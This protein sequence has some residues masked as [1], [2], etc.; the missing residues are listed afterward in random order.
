M[1]SAS[2]CPDPALLEYLLQGL[3]DESQARV[4]E[5]HLELCPTCLARLQHLER[6][7]PLAQALEHSSIPS[8]QASLTEMNVAALVERFKA[9]PARRSDTAIGNPPGR[10]TPSNAASAGAPS[11]PETIPAQVGP[12]RVEEEI[13]KGGMG[14]IVRVR[15]ADFDRPLAMKILLERDADSEERFL[16]EARLTGVLQHP[17]IPPVHA[18]GR[19]DDGR[20]FFI[21]K[22]IQ[23]CSLQALLSERA[24]PA[25]DLLRFVGIFAQVCQTVGYA[26]ARGVIHRDLK[27]SNIMVGAFGE[28]QVMDWGLAKVL[29]PASAETATPEP[30]GTVYRVRRAARTGDDTETGSVMGTPSYMAPEQARGKVEHLDARADV[31][32]LGAILC[33][34]LTGRPPFTGCDALDQAEQGELTDALARLNACA[35]DAELVDLARRCLAPRKA[36]RPADG[37]AVAQGVANYLTEMQRR[38]HQAEVERAAADARAEEEKKLRAAEAARA[39]EEVRRRA[40]EAAHALA[41]RRRRRISFALT[42]TILLVLAAGVSGAIQYQVH[43][44][45]QH[46]L[47]EAVTDFTEALKG[48]DGST[49]QRHALA[50]KAWQLELLDPE[51]GMKAAADLRVCVA[52]QLQA[53]L[54]LGVS[55]NQAD[56]FYQQ[57]DRALAWLESAGAGADAAKLRDE[58]K[59]R[60]TVTESRKW[61][62]QALLPR[63]VL[64]GGD[65]QAR[66]QAAVP[67]FVPLLAPCPEFA[68]LEAVFPSGSWE[69]ATVAATALN[70]NDAHHGNVLHLAVRNRDNAAITVGEDQTIKVW[71]LA[72]NRVVQTL[73]KADG[74]QAAAGFASAN[75]AVV[76]SVDGVLQFWDI[77]EGKPLGAGQPLDIGRNSRLAMLGDS[78]DG[79]AGGDNG[80][81]VRFD[82]EGACAEFCRESWPIYR[83]VA[84]P[85]GRHVALV[86]WW[87]GKNRP[88][89]SVTVW[90][91]EGGAGERRWKMRGGAVTAGAFSADGRTL[92]VAVSGGPIQLRDAATGEVQ[93]SLTGGTGG[94]PALALA[95]APNGQTLAA[96]TGS[97]RVYLLPLPDGSSARYDA[98]AGVPLELAWLGPDRLLIAG[99]SGRMT[100]LSPA[101]GQLTPGPRA[102]GYTLVL[103]PNR[104]IPY[105]SSLGVTY[106]VSGAQRLGDAARRG[107]LY[108]ALYR[109]N[110]LLREMR[111]PVVSGEPLRLWLARR[112]GDLTMQINRHK[113]A[114]FRDP[115]AIHGDD[116]G[117]FG[118]LVGPQLAPSQV[119]ATW[120]LLPTR[121]TARQLADRAF[122]RQ[123]YADAIVHLRQ[124]GRDGLL[125]RADEAEVKYKEALCLFGQNLPERAQALLR[126]VAADPGGGAWSMLAL[127]RRG[128][129]LLRTDAQQARQVF[130]GLLHAPAEVVLLEVISPGTRDTIIRSYQPLVAI[131]NL[132]RPYPRRIQELHDLEALCRLLESEP[133]SRLQLNWILVHAYLRDE[134]PHRA[135]AIAEKMRER[136][137]PAMTGPMRR[138][139]L[140]TLIWL[141]SRTGRPADSEALLQS[142][143][144][145]SDPQNRLL[146]LA[147]RVRLHLRAREY[148]EAERVLDELEPAVVN[149]GGDPERRIWFFF[150]SVCRGFARAAAQDEQGA[151]AAWTRGYELWHIAPAYDPLHGSMLASLSGRLSAS[152][153]RFLTESVLAQLT[154]GGDQTIAPLLKDIGLTVLQPTINTLL[155][156][157]WSSPR[158]RTLARQ[159]V[160]HELG[161]LDEQTAQ[162]KLVGHGLLAYFCFLRLPEEERAL[163]DE[164][165]WTFAEQTH[166]LYQSGTLTELDIQRCALATYT[167]A[168]TEQL[169]KDKEGILPQSFLARLRWMSGHRVRAAGRVVEAERLFRTVLDIADENAPVRTL[170]Q[171]ALRGLKKSE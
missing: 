91:T 65:G 43:R 60:Q 99:N 59:Q 142:L 78:G 15:D 150:A 157:M 168:D 44:T 155:R 45:R 90:S 138:Q 69:S 140:E 12:Y 13:N 89:A 1:S 36:E 122:Y 93:Q 141:Y 41:E 137:D 83:I 133:L 38:L 128:E 22:L 6:T 129:W 52:D 25:A 119:T 32:G 127:A 144:K 66:V 126:E 42:A 82:A 68:E 64:G 153:G 163:L 139:L 80:R 152:D 19:L 112:G 21:M 169:L 123:Q 116:T 7:D 136:D 145:S 120:Q 84:D 67:Q 27:P 74:V 46:E 147:E 156:H 102:Q 31:F 104:A 109:D 11:R 135:L 107:P 159:V 73:R 132:V 62:E 170:A 10:D 33:E 110:S 146:A 23:G 101:T 96:A 103:R 3:L 97:G 58:L 37:A 50:E 154:V 39:D 161:Y 30:E 121:P 54:K 130:G 2:P 18:L 34:I 4:L 158:G 61:P 47:Q 148:S 118:L 51:A 113:A 166:G 105:H 49:V 108:A 164:E 171:R 28:V 20:P 53:R 167:G 92:A 76:L 124:A 85:M 55:A 35:A 106:G 160:L 149:P 117:S 86:S 26:H 151:L 114:L 14:R 94:E 17:G 24:S 134:Q 56:D 9:F 100:W 131:P 162:V 75:R 63:T 98:E 88:D 72:T 29:K 77:A 70:A 111:V 57:F 16:R 125:T 48:F 40:A 115:T 81:I 95:F 79:L 71:D 87:N 143:T 8:D 165:L 5:T